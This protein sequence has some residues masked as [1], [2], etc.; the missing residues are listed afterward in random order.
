MLG[1]GLGQV[2][3]HLYLPVL[4]YIF[5]NIVDLIVSPLHKSASNSTIPVTT[6]SK[7]SAEYTVFFYRLLTLSVRGPTLDI[8]IRRLL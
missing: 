3:R 4:K 5:N 2:H 7:T 1:P 6:I 8:R